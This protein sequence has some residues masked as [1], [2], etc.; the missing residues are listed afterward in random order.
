MQFRAHRG[1]PGFPE[2][3]MIAF[4]KAVEE[5]FEQIETDPQYTKD[6]VIVLIH[7]IRINR[8]CRYPDGSVI[9]NEILRTL[10]IH[11][12]DPSYTTLTPIDRFCVAIH[13]LAQRATAQ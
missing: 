7:D 3:T 5:G 6:G 12:G 9:P 1:H 13:S 10:R 8:T 2:N 4:R 11:E